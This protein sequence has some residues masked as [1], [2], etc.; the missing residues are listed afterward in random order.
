MKVLNAALASDATLT[1]MGSDF[2][3]PEPVDLPRPGNNFDTKRAQ[4]RFD[5]ADDKSLRFKRLDM[6]DMCLNRAEQALKWLSTPGYT[7]LAQDEQAK[8]L[9]VARGGCV[10]AFNFHPMACHEAYRVAVPV[11]LALEPR[12]FVALDTGEARFGGSSIDGACDFRRLWGSSERPEC[13]WDVARGELILA[14]PPR[15]AL[16]LAPASCAAT[17]K[18]DGLFVMP[19][20]DTFVDALAV[21]ESP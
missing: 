11:G 1:W 5:L 12:L 3:Y 4:V 17:L 15:T 21:V 20:A 18:A 8:V 6:F 19:T 7:L 10:F 9:V 14:L 2:G 13:E 16:L